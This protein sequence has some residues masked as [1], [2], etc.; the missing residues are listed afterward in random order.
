MSWNAALVSMFPRRSTQ[1][2]LD[3][4][5]RSPS[6]PVSLWMRMNVPVP[7]GEKKYGECVLTHTWW[8]WAISTRA[9]YRTRSGCLASMYSSAEAVLA[10]R[11]DLRE[12]MREAEERLKEDSHRVQ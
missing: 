10:P 1:R 11:I 9:S 4:G 12:W 2:T 3:E 7:R 5:G 8:S 6:A